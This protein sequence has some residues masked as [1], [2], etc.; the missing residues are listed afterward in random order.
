MFDPI[1]AFVTRGASVNILLLIYAFLCLLLLIY[2]Y[3]EKVLAY[4]SIQGNKRR[5]LLILFWTS[6]IILMLFELS[7]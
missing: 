6:V 2:L 1:V 4:A 7:V 3:R 5:N